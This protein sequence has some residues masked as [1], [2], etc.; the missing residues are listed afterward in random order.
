MELNIG[1]NIK[2]LRLAKGFTQEQLANLLSVSAAAVSKWEAKNIYPDITML[3]PLAEIFQVS[4]DEL[5]GY[6]QIKAKSDIDRLITEYQTL[7]ANVHI[8]EASELIAAARKKYPHDYRIMNAYMWDKAGGKA[9]NNAETLL[10]NQKELTQI[11]NCILEGCTLENLRIDAINMK[12]KLLHIQGDTEGA[13]EILSQLPDLQAPMAKE[14]LFG[15]DTPGFRYWNKKNCYGLL[16]VIAIKH[17]RAVWYDPLL[18]TADKIERIEPIAEA[19]SDM[20][21]KKDFE[22]FRIG[23]QAVY[24]FLADMLTLGGAAVEDVIRIREK[25]FAAMEKIMRLAEADEILSESIEK[26][27]K[28]NNMIAWGV[29][30]LLSSPHPQFA[31]YRESAEYMAVMSEWKRKGT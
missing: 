21:Q 27:Y 30:R 16:N 20:S 12:A 29:N 10:E 28:T 25:Q 2:R 31:K 3:Y 18:S 1:A 8:T 4:M 9:G 19:Y 26:T 7:K 24:A 17:A 11:C 22:F 5:L 13:L 6:D 14:Q 15:K 23:E